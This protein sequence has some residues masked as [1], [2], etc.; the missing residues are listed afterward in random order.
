MVMEINF[1]SKMKIYIRI[2][3]NIQ[4]KLKEWKMKF[5]SK[6]GIAKNYSKRIIE[7][8]LTEG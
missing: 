2:I 8:K 4:I 7:W 6:F 3:Y 5:L 1:N